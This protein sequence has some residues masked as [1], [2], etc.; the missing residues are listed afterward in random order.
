MRTLALSVCALLAAP[1]PCVAQNRAAPRPASPPAPALGL[2][3][4]RPGATLPGSAA[5]RLLGDPSKPELFVARFR[6]PDGAGVGPHWHTTTLHI[7]VLSGTLVLGMGD[8][9]DSTAAQRYGPGSF[10]VLEGG[11]HHYEWFQGETVVH[12]EGVGPFRTVF[13]N[14]ADDPRTAPPK[15]E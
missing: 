6:Y 15:P 7:T 4:W 10:L 9:V 2:T 12:V 11:M 13:V 5:M 8:K 3:E 1:V 14:P